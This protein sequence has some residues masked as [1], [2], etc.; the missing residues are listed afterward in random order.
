LNKDN[1][2]IFVIVEIA[3]DFTSFGQPQD[4]FPSATSTIFE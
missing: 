2:D 3:S 1:N 4:P